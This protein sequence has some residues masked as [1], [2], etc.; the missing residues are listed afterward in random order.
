M[1]QVGHASDPVVTGRRENARLRLR[2]PARLTLL[3]RAAACLIVDISR[4]GA[5]LQIDSPPKVGEF[6]RIECGKLDHFFDVIWC[7]GKH[8]GVA[9]DVPISQDMLLHL[10]GVHDSSPNPQLSDTKNLAR[11][12]VNGELK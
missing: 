8:I 11:R 5:Q 12:W 2:L 1:M 4:S 7:F 6:G 3:D 9:F 10:R